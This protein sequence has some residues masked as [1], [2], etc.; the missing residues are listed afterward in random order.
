MKS[1]RKPISKRTRFRIF[2][3]DGFTCRYCG[4]QSDSAVLVV[5]HLI[6]VKEGGT[7]DDENL[8]TAC[9]PCNQGK[10]AKKLDQ[11]APTDADRLRMAQERNEQVRAAESA[12]EAV[13]A[14]EEFRQ[15]VCN[16]WCEIRGTEN[17][18]LQTLNTMVAYATQHGI[19]KVAEWIG[20]AERRIPFKKD[21]D[22][23]RYVSGIRRQ[24]IERGEL[25][26]E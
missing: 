7:N 3:R 21:R 19:P 10:A 12:M 17:V 13:Q 5:D 15:H 23:G 20:I 8:I 11:H 9:E 22:I 16:L 14:R 18:D 4:A 6:P 24:L 2:A 1:E 25:E 26:A